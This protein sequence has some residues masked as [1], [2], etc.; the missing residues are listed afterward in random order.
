[1]NI[2]LA[3]E[4]KKR[5]K[6]S[7]EARSRRNFHFAK[8]SLIVLVSGL[9]CAGA[10]TWFAPAKK[11]PA[12]SSEASKW[13]EAAA[14]SQTFS[15]ASASACDIFDSSLRMGPRKLQEFLGVHVPPESAEIAMK[16]LEIFKG[17]A[18]SVQ[19]VRTKD[20]RYEV[21]CKVAGNGHRLKFLMCGEA[22]QLRLTGVDMMP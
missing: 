6:A 9:L 12:A 5:L 8:I 17:G 18:L 2:A 16:T 15:Q 19:K 22:G 10:F 21:V 1:M 7:L 13:K 3:I 20:L 14:G 11:A 4:E